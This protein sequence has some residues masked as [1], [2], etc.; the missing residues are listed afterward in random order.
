MADRLLDSLQ[1]ALVGGLSNVFTVLAVALF[2]RVRTGDETEVT[3][4]EGWRSV[5]R[6]AGE[7]LPL[8]LDNDD[9]DIVTSMPSQSLN[10]LLAGALL[11]DL[12]LENRIDTDLERVTLVDATPVGSNLLDPVLADMARDTEPR[13]IDYRL[14]RTAMRGDEIREKA[15]AGLVEQG[16]VETDESVAFFLSSRVWHFRRYPTIDGTVTEEVQ[17]RVMRLLFSDDIPDPRD[18]VIVSLAAAGDVFKH[19]LSQEELAEARDRIDLI[20][21]LDL[22][23]QSVACVLRSAEPTPFPSVR[24]PWRFRK[25]LGY[26]SSAMR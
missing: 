25:P 14:E 3:R 1:I 7:L 5:P 12:A 24:L 23:G 8:I 22:I 18:I 17:F 10:T 4:M 20:S 21:R 16:I 2:L 13:T 6:F 19:L 9:G 15:L 26:P 11:M